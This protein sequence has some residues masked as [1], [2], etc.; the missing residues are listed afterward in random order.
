MILHYPNPIKL[1]DFGILIPVAPDRTLQVL[2]ALHER[3]G[4]GAVDAVVLHPD[5]VVIDREDLLRVHHPGYVDRVLGTDVEAVM[6]DVFELLDEEGRYNRY[7]PASAARPLA[8]LANDWRGWMAG[9]Y[10]CTRIALRDG[11]CFY[12]GGGAHHGHYE[13]GHGFC[14]F[15]DIVVAARKLTAEQAASTVWIIDV[16][17]HKGDGTAALTRDDPAITSLSVHMG[18]GWPLDLPRTDARGNE[19]PSFVPSDIDV[20]IGPGEEAS[21]LPRLRSALSQLAEYPLPDLA[22]VVDGADPYEHDELPSTAG[23]RL[24]LAQMLE[25]DQM[26]YRFLAHRG[27]PQAYLMAGGYG[28][29]AWEPPA[30]FLSWV[31]SER[32]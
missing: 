31:L 18:A 8:E 3:L 19:H 2:T 24:S 25:R 20:P 23:L 21:Y 16:D 29:R 30:A 26:I 6:M 7:D 22:I 1:R 4:T 14:V 17:A 11:F 12:L 28:A 9:T 15:N 32:C 10:Q 5:G 13:F 27:I